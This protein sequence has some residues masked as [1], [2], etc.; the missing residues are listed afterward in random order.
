MRGTHT[1]RVT[2]VCFCSS[3][4]TT[5]LFVLLPVMKAPNAPMNGLSKGK[6]GAAATQD[7]G[8]QL[9]HA[10]VLHDDGHGHQRI[11]AD[12]WLDRAANRLGDN[13]IG[14]VGASLAP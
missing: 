1:P 6:E 11:N 5:L 9:G 2:A 4:N 14:A 10:R 3:P 12:R 13:R 8:Q 7:I